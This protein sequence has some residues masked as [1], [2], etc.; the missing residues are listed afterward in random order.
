MSPNRQPLPE[1][2]IRRQSD[3]QL[4][5]RSRM[6]AKRDKLE[7]RIGRSESGVVWLDRVRRI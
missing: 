3:E 2:A 7:S 5:Q 1:S 6:A 4:E